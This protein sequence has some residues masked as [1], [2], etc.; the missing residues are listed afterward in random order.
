MYDQ[1]LDRL[2]ATDAAEDRLPGDR[3]VL[4][5]DVEVRK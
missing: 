4:P 5:D 2:I 1:S 3:V